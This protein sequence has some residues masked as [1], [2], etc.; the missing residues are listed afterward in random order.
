MAGLRRTIIGCYIKPCAD[1][2]PIT[3]PARLQE[4]AVTAPCSKALAAQFLQSLKGRAMQCTS[5]RKRPGL[6]LQAG[7]AAPVDHCTALPNIWSC[8]CPHGPT[9]PTAPKC[10]Y[11]A[12][13]LRPDPLLLRPPVCSRFAGPRPCSA[14]ERSWGPLLRGIA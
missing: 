6:L 2:I 14:R 9:W 13:L 5:Y 12:L 11:Q 1:L 10:Q 8:Y 3:R 4:A 7:R